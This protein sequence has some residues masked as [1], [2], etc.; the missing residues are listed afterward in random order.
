MTDFVR[1]PHVSW[2]STA[3]ALF[4]AVSSTLSPFWSSAH[5]AAAPTA[6]LRSD[7]ADAVER[8]LALFDL[9]AGG[10][11]QSVRLTGLAPSQTFEFGV[12]RDE[13]ISS[14]RVHLVWTSSPSL[15]AGKSQLNAYLN[16]RLV[17][18][19]PLEASS[20]GQTTALDVDLT[21]APLQPAG[22]R[23]RLE[24]IG[25]YQ[26]VCENDTHS[27]LWLEVTDDS[28]LTLAG[29][30]VRIANDLSVLPAPFV[31]AA[32][33]QA[34]VVP[35][36]F[37]ASPD[38]DTRPA[39]AITAGT[40]CYHFAMR[41]LVGTIVPHWVKNPMKHRWFQQK[42]FEAKLYAALKVK[43]WKAHMPTYNP[44][45]FSLRENSLEQII[46]NCCV[47]EAVHETIILLSFLP[48]FFTLLW[49]AFPVFLITSLLA[50]A[51]DSCFVI[52]QRYNRPRLVQTL[53]K[54]EAK[55]RE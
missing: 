31:D 17:K 24:L 9:A 55:A 27:S 42:S 54:K 33:P 41:L 1:F 49:G 44:A 48:L 50:A 36:V 21:G 30:S 25:H 43:G 34:A 28:T 40:T 37:A 14:A 3:L 51:F 7:G 32:D 47:S 8:T 19:I 13:V 6:A 16:G 39:A 20:I 53:S 11:P 4:F 29:E 26:T 18:S 5:A 35:M 38:E 23:L 12:R 46:D 45:S 10:R 2:Q 15:V 52:M 22:N